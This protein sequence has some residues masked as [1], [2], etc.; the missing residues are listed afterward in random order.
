M[1]RLKLCFAGPP[2]FWPS[3]NRATIDRRARLTLLARA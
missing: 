2:Y 1:A 3:P